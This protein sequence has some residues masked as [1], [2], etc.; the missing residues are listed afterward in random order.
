MKNKLILL[1]Y[2]FLIIAGVVLFIIGLRADTTKEISK[3]LVIASVFIIDVTLVL[4]TLKIEKLN[5]N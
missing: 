2:F 1:A 5:G 3:L 4:I